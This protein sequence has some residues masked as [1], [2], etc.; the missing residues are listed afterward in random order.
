MPKES[1]QFEGMAVL[2]LQRYG[3]VKTLGHKQQYLVFL[4]MALFADS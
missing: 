2:P 1:K 3:R 4:I